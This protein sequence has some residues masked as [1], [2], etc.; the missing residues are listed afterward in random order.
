MTQGVFHSLGAT[1][2]PAAG[3]SVLGGVLY[4]T[5]ADLERVAGPAALLRVSAPVLGEAPGAGSVLLSAAPLTHGQHGPVHFSCSDELFFGV[6]QLDEADESGGLHALSARAYAAIFAALDAHGYPTLLR[7][8]NYLPDINRETEG[9]ERYRQFNAGRQEAFAASQRP[10]SGKV[11]AA[12]ALGT[13]AG[14]LSIAFLGSV[15][16]FVP[17]ENPRQVSAYHYPREYGERSPTFSRAGLTR[18]GGRDVLFISGTAAIVGHQSLHGDD[19]LAQTDETLVNLAAVVEAANAYPS[20]LRHSLRSLDYTVYVRHA[21][22][23]PAVMA[24][25][26]EAVGP[27]ARMVCVRA[28]VCRSELLVEIEAVGGLPAGAN[29]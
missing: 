7:A 23:A 20:A 12:C 25:V 14:G 16:P 17:V 15:T 24:R 5:S 28:D 3:Q 10:L 18:I 29:E 21:A 1:L 13:R 9:L 8:W 19:V 27:A 4:G 26:R 2:A 6:L 11:P 22:D